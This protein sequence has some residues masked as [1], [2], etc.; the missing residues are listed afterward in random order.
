MQRCRR[1]VETSMLTHLGNCLWWIFAAATA[2]NL[3]SATAVVSAAP[4]PDRG[5]LLAYSN[6]T[7][8]HANE[9]D[10][11]KSDIAAVAQKVAEHCKDDYRRWL[12]VMTRGAKSQ[13]VT[14]NYEMAF[15][16]VMYERARHDPRSISIAITWN[17]TILW[18]NEPISCEE[19]DRRLLAN[20]PADKPKPELN[21]CKAMNSPP[22]API[23]PK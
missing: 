20:Y 4:S 21:S 12:V 16:T 11:G 1:R 23:P 6:C 17:G 14:S 15:G 9:I 5:E 10:D 19:L 3:V 7:N 2:F 13:G 8:T 22:T 18:N